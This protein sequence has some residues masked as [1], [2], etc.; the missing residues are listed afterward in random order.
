MEKENQLPLESLTIR[1]SANFSPRKLFPIL[2][3]V[4]TNDPSKLNGKWLS[5]KERKERIISET[6][7]LV[8]LSLP[9]STNVDRCLR[10]SLVVVRKKPETPKRSS[11]NRVTSTS[12]SDSDIFSDADSNKI[13]VPHSTAGLPMYLPIRQ[14]SASST[15]SSNTDYGSFEVET[16]SQLFDRYCQKHKQLIEMEKSVE[17]L[18]F[19]LLEISHKLEEAKGNAADYRNLP[20]PSVKQPSTPLFTKDLDAAN[21]VRSLTKK[22]SNIFSAGASDTENKVATLTKKASAIFQTPNGQSISSNRSVTDSPSSSASPLKNKQSVVDIFSKLQDQFNTNMTEI[23][24]KN[25]ELASNATKFMNGIISNLSPRKKD[26]QSRDMVDASLIL[27]EDDTI[28]NNS[29]IFSEDSPD[30]SHI[31]HEVDEEYEEEEE[32]E[33]IRIV[34]IDDYELSLEDF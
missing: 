30:N 24:Q 17:L 5:V 2:T 31:I 18:K 13:S 11:Y 14:P 16:E 15:L 34:D 3:P 1:E 29:A 21:V 22:A 9:N 25:D 28:F 7:G 6:T 26:H 23:K 20:F 12:E 27:D 19:E 10:Q 32:E 33:E 4:N 8:K